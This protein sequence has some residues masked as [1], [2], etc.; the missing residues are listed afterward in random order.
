MGT[1][2]F[3]PSG[4]F[5]E[6]I[7]LDDAVIAALFESF[8]V[9]DVDEIIPAEAANA[10]ETREPARETPKSNYQ[11][12]E[13]RVEVKAGATERDSGESTVRVPSKQL[14]HINDLFGELIIQRNGLNL[15]LERLRKLIRSL[16]QRVQVLE[17]ENQELRTA[18]DKMSTGVASS[19]NSGLS[20]SSNAL[21]D[22]NYFGGDNGDLS[23]ITTKFDA[24]EMDRYNE[25]NLLSQEVMETIVQVQ[26]VSTDIQLSLDDTDQLNRKLNKTSK[27][28]QRKLTQVRMRPLSD[29]TDRFP[30]AIRDLN[31]EYGKNAQLKVEG[32]NTL[33]ERSILESLNEP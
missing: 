23:G 31:V 16:N 9:S 10:A 29:I 11:Y 33:I 27:Q 17:R 7:Q 19:A 26:E 28:L 18:Y 5:A 25:L 22:D 20:F 24:L 14:E 12:T 3:S 8:E 30:R 6:D 1:E 32:A 4:A 13:P 2:D 21:S 15:Q